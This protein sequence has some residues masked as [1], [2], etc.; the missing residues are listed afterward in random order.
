[1]CTS[2]NPG[3]L[4]GGDYCRRE[5][6]ASSFAS[7]RKISKFKNLGNISE[8]LEIYGN[9]YF[10]FEKRENNLLLHQT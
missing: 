3:L 7:V 10:L 9:L 5:E 1:M 8:K 2:P 4:L 6:A